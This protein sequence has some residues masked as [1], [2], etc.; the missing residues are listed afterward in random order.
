MDFSLNLF[1]F[2]GAS[3]Q[4]KRPWQK[5][6][7][8]PILGGLPESIKRLDELLAKLPRAECLVSE[9]TRLHY[10]IRS[11]L[12]GF[13]DDLYIEYHPEDNTLQVCSKARTGF[14]DFGVNRRRILQLH[15]NYLLDTTRS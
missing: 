5:V 4:S 11:K 3:S 8:F 13:I 10:T 2:N 12:F 9:K 7:P 15:R 1:C 14:Y 6:A